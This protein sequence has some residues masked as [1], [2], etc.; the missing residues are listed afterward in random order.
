[1][2]E[3]ETKPQPW[4]TY[5]ARVAGFIQSSGVG[6]SPMADKCS[7]LI[8]TVAFVLSRGYGSW[9]FWLS[10]LA[11]LRFSAASTYLWPARPFNKSSPESSFTDVSGYGGVQIIWAHAQVFALLQATFD[12][13]K[14]L[15]SLNQVCPVCQHPEDR[16]MLMSV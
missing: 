9:R 2:H 7:E 8:L 14:F 3:F 4:E 1:M 11:T 10:L 12:V 6:K 16:T 15:N 5:Y 13:C